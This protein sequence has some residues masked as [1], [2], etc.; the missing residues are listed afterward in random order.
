MNLQEMQAKIAALEGQLAESQSDAKAKVE[1]LNAIQAENG[2][3]KASIESLKKENEEKT[4]ALEAALK[5]SQE[6]KTKASEAS[7][8]AVEACAAQSHAAVNAETKEKEIDHRAEYKRL[9]SED[10]RKA[11]DYYAKHKA[12]I[13]G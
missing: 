8:V 13:L 10:H 9:H 5:E 7:K 6:A 11:A 12:Q 1:S 3:L 2:A 4:K